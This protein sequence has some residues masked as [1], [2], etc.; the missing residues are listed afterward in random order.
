M[1]AQFVAA[2]MIGC[3]LSACNPTPTGSPT[4]SAVVI[5]TPTATSTS[6]PEAT[7]APTIVA[8][9]TLFGEFPGPDTTVP[10]GQP[11]LQDVTLEDLA[12]LW[13]S[14]GLTCESHTAGG[15]ESPAAY[16]VHCERSDPAANLHVVSDAAYW[17]NDG[18]ATL[19]ITATSIDDGAIDGPT[20]ATHWI[21]PFVRLA[22]GDRA[23]RWL[24]QLVAGTT[25][26]DGCKDHFRGSQFSYR[27][28]LRGSQSLHVVAPAPTR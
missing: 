27:T 22:G 15:P 24:Q 18:I 1:R 4:A 13:A 9:P 21:L 2:A 3:L 19:S 23:E 10:P 26:L 8:E 12:G 11:V 5:V 7:V 6:F 25:C 17:T 16:N 14:L 20:A 28:G